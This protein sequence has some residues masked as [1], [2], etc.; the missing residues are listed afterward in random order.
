MPLCKK[1]LI[2]LKWGF[3]HSPGW[4]HTGESGRT[5]PKPDGAW[6]PEETVDYMLEKVSLGDFYIVCP[7]N[8]VSSV[9]TL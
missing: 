3:L 5:K 2:D 6:S 8:D 9:S 7:D 1:P 4:V